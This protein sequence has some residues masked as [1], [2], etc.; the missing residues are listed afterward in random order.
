MIEPAG[1]RRSGRDEVTEAVGLADSPT[2]G[3]VVRVTLDINRR[4][5]IVRT[6]F[7][8]YGCG[9][10]MARTSDALQA[11]EGKTVEQA[12]LVTQAAATREAFPENGNGGCAA[13][14]Q[15][16]LAALDDF[17]RQRG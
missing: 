7:R 6:G 5:L 3:D 11:I 17:V 10:A 13:V 1:P 8:V 16:V 14:E 15:A 4:R 12:R 2:C 9:S